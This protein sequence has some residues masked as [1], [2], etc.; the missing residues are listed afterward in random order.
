MLPSCS[1]EECQEDTKSA[2]QTSARKVR[3]DICWGIGWTLSTSQLAQY[4]ADGEVVNIVASHTRIRAIA[5]KACESSNDQPWILRQD[6]VDGR[7]KRFQYARPE[8][9]K[10]DID[11]TQNGLQQSDPATGFEVNSYR[12][13]STGQKVGS[14]SRRSAAISKGMGSVNPKN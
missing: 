5:A 10:K 8:G 13:F 14:S 7:Q 6:I 2:H 1:R 9:I 4:T 12:A 3:E 11:V